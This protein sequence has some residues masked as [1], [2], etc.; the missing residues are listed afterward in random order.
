[1]TYRFR[2]LR[3]ISTASL[4]ILSA[5]NFKIGSW[6]AIPAEVL[7]II[8]VYLLVKVALF[9]IHTS[10]LLTVITQQGKLFLE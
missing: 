6:V 2:E 5:P 8:K 1:M 9:W 4:L 3:A 10:V 7:T